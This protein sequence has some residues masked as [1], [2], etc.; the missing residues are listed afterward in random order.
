MR[1][2]K[3]YGEVN[4]FAPAQTP[5]E[6]IVDID[7]PPNEALLRSTYELPCEGFK[8]LLHE[9]LTEMYS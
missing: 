4:H 2:L 5:N 9:M 6:F 3:P 1:V 7:N 8:L